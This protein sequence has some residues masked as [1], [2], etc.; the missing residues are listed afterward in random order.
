MENVKI[1]IIDHFYIDELAPCDKDYVGTEYKIDIPYRLRVGDKL[2]TISYWHRGPIEWDTTIVD[3]NEK[4]ITVTSRF[5]KENKVIPW[6]EES[7]ESRILVFTP[8]PMFNTGINKKNFNK[9]TRTIED[10]TL[11][12]VIGGIST[13]IEI[14]ELKPYV[15]NFKNINPDLSKNMDLVNTSD[16]YKFVNYINF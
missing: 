5:E 3:I 11:K 9:I 14:N 7:K 13:N 2:R 8:F 10:F 15:E 16:K 1:K 4:G 12:D 6:I